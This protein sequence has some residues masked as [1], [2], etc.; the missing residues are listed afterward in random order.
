M[1]NNKK[2]AIIHYW[3]VNMRGGEKMLEALL[4]LFP[5]VDVFTH[6]LNKNALSDRIKSHAIYTSGIQKLPYAKKWYQL[7]MPLMPRALLDFDLHD[8]DLVISSEAGPAKGIVPNPAAY[9]LCYCHSPARY[10]WDLYHEYVRGLPPPVRALIRRLVP[11]LRVWDVTS[12]NLVDRFVTNSHYTAQRIKR[13]YNREADVV[14]GPVEIEKFLRAKREPAG[15]Y[16]C[17][18]QITPYKRIDLAAE[19]C[20]NAGKRLIV[21]GGGDEP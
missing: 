3:L 9:H 4:E 17:A 8:Y 18:G 10:I 13:Y 6:V 12:A 1:H 5:D 7:Y 20:I 2:T 19:A 21:A 16:L 11:A 15:Y 14:F